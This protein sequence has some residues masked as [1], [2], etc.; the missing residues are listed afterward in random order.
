M[1][2]RNIS[3]LKSWFKKGM[4]PTAA[5]FADWL[6]S[7]WHKEDKL[8]ISSIDRLADQ[9]NGKYPATDGEQ[10]EE[11]H[12]QLAIDFD[13][14][15]LEATEQFAAIYESIDAL[16]SATGVFI[17]DKTIENCLLGANID[18]G[19]L[20][21][22]EQATNFDIP[23]KL[24]PLDISSN[25]CG[26]CSVT[27]DGAY[28]A[29]MK[30]SG[31]S[32]RV[33]I[34]KQDQNIFT[35]LFSTIDTTRATCCFSSDGVY[36]MIG[37]MYNDTA[38][39]YKRSGD[40]F[41]T[42]PITLPEMSLGFSFTYDASYL[43][44]MHLKAP[45]LT[46]YKRDGDSFVQLPALESLTMQGNDCSFTADGS[47][48]A[49]GYFA[50]PFLNIYKR[51]GDNFIKLPTL[52]IPTDCVYGC[53]FTNNGNYLTV[54]HSLAPF[55]TIYKRDGDS[56]T[57]LPNISVPTEYFA[58]RCSFTSN[59]DYLAVILSYATP[60]IYKRNGDEYVKL[61]P[62]DSGLLG[63]PLLDIKYI[64]FASDGSFLV[65]S[66]PSGMAMF[67]ESLHSVVC[68]SITKTAT[69]TAKGIAMENGTAYETKPILMLEKY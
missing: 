50:S 12:N 9:L 30:W 14:H 1:A 20:V 36:L 52:E 60:V 64:Q 5:Q 61:P 68:P 27:A 34:Y 53:C 48:L 23:E 55:V 28:V 38:I 33:C 21:I 11:R 22:E 10:L 8:P 44:V 29:V 7:F 17:N 35:L 62:I 58:S 47:Y 31:S 46:I 59:G 67:K 16:G 49:A 37:G 15:K 43:A 41:T 42:T 25:A 51:D 18:K 2:I 40:S 4:Y 65:M 63:N 39:L 13:G 6:D 56:F 69:S 24:P 3:Q 54:C 66:G 45:Y 19:D 32:G 26:E 57:K